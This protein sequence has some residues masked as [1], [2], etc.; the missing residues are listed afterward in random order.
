M[1]GCSCL[2]RRQF[3]RDPTDAL[4]ADQSQSIRDN[5]AALFGCIR[6]WNCSVGNCS[7]TECGFRGKSP[8]NPDDLAQHSDLISLGVPLFGFPVSGSRA[9]TSPSQRL[10]RCSSL[11]ICSTNSHGFITTALRASS[12]RRRA[13]FSANSTSPVPWPIPGRIPVLS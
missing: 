9:S 3:R 5:L 13:P 12:A 1:S 4:F 7:S 11:F 6:A 8:A 10:L 2:T